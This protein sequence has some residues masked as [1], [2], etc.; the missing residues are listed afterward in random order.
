MTNSEQ[1]GMNLKRLRKSLDISQEE[2]GFRC[3]LHRTEI[4]MI[5]RAVRRPSFDTIVKLSVGLEAPVSSL[6]RRVGWEAE[7]SR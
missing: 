7:T 2:L 6:F 5:E 3:D 1:F 4:S